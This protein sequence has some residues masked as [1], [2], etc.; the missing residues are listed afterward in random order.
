MR[1]NLK[2]FRIKERLSQAEISERIGC[3]RATYAAIESGSRCGRMRFWHDLQSAFDLPD[4]EM[5]EL[6]DDDD[7]TKH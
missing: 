3:S 5:W 2:I 7:T 6:M 1:R 4:S